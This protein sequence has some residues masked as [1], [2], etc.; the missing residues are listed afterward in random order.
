MDLVVLIVAFGV[1]W[2]LLIAP[3]RRQLRR[4]QELVASLEVGDEVIT[5]SGIFGTVVEL[6]EDTMLLEVSPGVRIR[7]VR[8]AV[9]RVAVDDG[10]DDDGTDDVSSGREGPVS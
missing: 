8:T 10:A 3:Q 2:M 5:S 4:H 1:M 7:M 6:D 9:S